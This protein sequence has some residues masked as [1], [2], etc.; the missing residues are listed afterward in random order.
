MLSRAIFAVAGLCLVIGIVLIA[1]ADFDDIDEYAP[2]LALVIIA[3]Y[4]LP[5]G[6]LAVQISRV[7][8]KVERLLA[9]QRRDDSAN[10][11]QQP[12]DTAPTTSSRGPRPVGTQP[13]RP[14]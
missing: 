5:T 7:D 12:T 8:E 13:R 11:P 2:G 1:G 9:Q 4:L 6:G 10:Q 14:K 3:L